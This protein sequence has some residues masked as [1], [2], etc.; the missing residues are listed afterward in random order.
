MFNKYSFTGKNFFQKT[1]IESLME[2]QEE[3]TGLD[4]L[5]PFYLLILLESGFDT[6][7]R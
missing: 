7:K 1:F 3:I 2:V 6:A 5:Q 4:H